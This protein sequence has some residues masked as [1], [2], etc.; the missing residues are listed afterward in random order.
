MD[1]TPNRFEKYKQAIL[2]I[3]LSK[4]PSCKVTLFGSRA[5]KTNQPGADIDLALDNCSP[6]PTQKLGEIAEIIEN[7]NMPLMVDL[8]DL[9]TATESLKKEVIREGIVWKA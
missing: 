4:L 8:V 1:T 7:S 2:D 6:I 3:I 5:R 9:H